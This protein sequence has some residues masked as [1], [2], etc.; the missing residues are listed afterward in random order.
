VV[1][2]NLD[3]LSSAC[4]KS[5]ES[6]LAALK[7]KLLKQY[8]TARETLEPGLQIIETNYLLDYDDTERVL[9]YHA[10]VQSRIAKWLQLFGQAKADRL[11]LIETRPLDVNSNGNGYDAL[12]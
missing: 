1:R 12:S 10:R 5:V 4:G 11:G 2:L 6:I 8:N 9:L 7:K 3:A